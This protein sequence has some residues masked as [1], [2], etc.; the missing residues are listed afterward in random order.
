MLCF[1]YIEEIRKQGSAGAE[2]PMQTRN[3][4]V[5]DFYEWN[6]PRIEQMVGLVEAV[7][8]LKLMNDQVEGRGK[9]D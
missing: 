6:D 3:T 8:D 1:L 4:Q 7:V 9:V 5:I 2:V